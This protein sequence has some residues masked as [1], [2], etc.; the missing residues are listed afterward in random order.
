MPYSADDAPTGDEGDGPTD[1]EPKEEEALGE[2]SASLAASQL[3]AARTACFSTSSGVWDATGGAASTP[4]DTAASLALATGGEGCLTSAAGWLTD[5]SA[6]R[7]ASVA[8]P[9]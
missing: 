4:S 5:D 6:A 3:R 7:T 2:G 8:P 9:P 1:G